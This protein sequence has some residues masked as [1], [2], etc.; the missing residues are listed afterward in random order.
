[1]F[2][3][4]LGRYILYIIFSCNIGLEPEIEFDSRTYAFIYIIDLALV[5][6]V[7]YNIIAIPIAFGFKIRFQPDS[8]FVLILIGIV[9]LH[10][11]YVRGDHPV[12][13]Y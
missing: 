3:I 13:N 11:R 7:Y 8:V 10:R 9:L 6:I 2:R 1:M 12:K 4:T 5:Q